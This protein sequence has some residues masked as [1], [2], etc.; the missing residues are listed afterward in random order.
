MLNEDGTPL[1]YGAKWAVSD[2]AERRQWLRDAGF[3]VYVGKP[4]MDVE[5]DEHEDDA[6]SRVDVWENGRA[7]IVFRWAGDEDPGVARG[8]SDRSETG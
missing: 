6:L 3:A 5:S 1:T 7:L 8:L 2:Q 4:G